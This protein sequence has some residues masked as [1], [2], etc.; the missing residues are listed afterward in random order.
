MHITSLVPDGCYNLLMNDQIQLIS[1]WLGSGS[2][3]FFGL[4]FAGKNTQADQFVTLLGATL[5]ASGDIFR[6]QKDNVELQQIM[7]TGAN[8][9]SDMFFDIVLPYF[10][11]PALTGRPLVLSEVGRKNGEQELILQATKESGHPT[12][13]VVL[14]SM[15]EAVVW[16][17]YEAA[18]MR[19]DRGDRLDDGDRDILAR[20]LDRF[21]VEI[22]PVIEFY[23]ERDLLIEVDGTLS[24]E[25]VT[26]EII[27]GLA[28]HAKA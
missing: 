20:R 24:R 4:P 14:L 8:I 15:P 13:A 6:A 3:N 28:T 26:D 1:Q 19:D 9:P 2:I 5:I 22:V 25:A 21:R 17:R 11:D 16:E 18:Q 12:K 23:R 10:N 7:A 27:K